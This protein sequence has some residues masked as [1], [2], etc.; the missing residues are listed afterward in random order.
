MSPSNQTILL[1]LTLLSLGLGFYIGAPFRWFSWHPLFMT[2]AWVA[3][4]LAA[5]VAKRQGGRANTLF[6]AYCMAGAALLTLSGYYVIHTH[7]NAMGKP[8]LTTYHSWTGIFVIGV[9]AVATVASSAL[10]ASRTRLHRVLT[11]RARDRVYRSDWSP[12]RPRHPADGEDG[13]RR[14][15]VRSPP[16]GGRCA[17]DHPFRVAQAGWRE[18]QHGGSRPWSGRCCTAAVALT[19][20][21]HAHVHRAAVSR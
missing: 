7:K 10:T 15:Q 12:S 13:A 8:H 20:P 1:N 6:H 14:A 16:H 4:A 3:L 5:I 9:S 17:C 2:L 21:A 11:S 19:H 18:L